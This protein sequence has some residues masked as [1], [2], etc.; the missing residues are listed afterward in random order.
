[1]N[2]L[3]SNPN[4]PDPLTMVDGRC[5]TTAQ[6]WCE[7]REELA[8][9][10]QRYMYGRAPDPLQ[11]TRAKTAFVDEGAFGGKATLKEVVLTL[12][13]EAMP[14]LRLLVATRHTFEGGASRLPS[15]AAL[16]SR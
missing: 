7:R 8:E 5:V 15:S 13:P 11:A 9:L 3:V 4:L 16:S 12:G 1:M 14:K 6:Q 10:F 2:E